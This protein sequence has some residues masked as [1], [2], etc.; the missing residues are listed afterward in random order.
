VWWEQRIEGTTVNPL[1]RASLLDSHGLPVTAEPMLIGTSRTAPAV[2]YGAGLFVVTREDNGA[3]VASRI[4]TDG[5]NIDTTPI[6]VRPPGGALSGP[7]ESSVAWN[8]ETFVI[9]WN[10]ASA[11]YAAAM[12]PDGTVS[13]AHMISPVVS[14]PDDPRLKT[15]FDR[16]RIA[17]DANRRTL[18][19]Y[20]STTFDQFVSDSG[21]LD[22]HVEA[23]SVDPLAVPVTSRISLS[24]SAGT[25]LL[26]AVAK[27][28]GSDYPL[29][30][31]DVT[32]VSATIIHAGQTLS[33]ESPQHIFTWPGGIAEPAVTWNGADYVA[34]WRYNVAPNFWLAPSV[35]SPSY[36]ATA[37]LDT[38]GHA[39]DLAVSR[40]AWDQL[41]PDGASIAIAS[42]GPGRTLTLTSETLPSGSDRIVAFTSGDFTAPPARP[43]PPRAARL[44]LGSGRSASTLSWLPADGDVDGYAIQAGSPDQSFILDIA[45]ENDRSA[46]NTI[47]QG[48]LMLSAFNAA[49]FSQPVAV[50]LAAPR[51]RSTAP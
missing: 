33:A 44:I 40:S 50:T 20:R 36:T 42:N 18:I 1:T 30:L 7:G 17:A 25:S 2:G 13:D 46:T 39:R 26:Q 14:H 3:L 41:P 19:T 12:R 49:G 29:L 34:S 47:G 23:V 4:R 45:C 11:I 16:P 8:G 28:A 37:T 43:G 32:G 15:V 5:S 6:V 48:P 27:G 9:A 51:R 31:S 35:P 21:P 10:E 22:I 24:P 38:G